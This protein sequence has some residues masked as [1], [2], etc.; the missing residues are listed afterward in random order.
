MGIGRAQGSGTLNNSARQRG[1]ELRGTAEV[2]SGSPPVLACRRRRCWPWSAGAPV[3]N[4]AKKCGKKRCSPSCAHF[5]ACNYTEQQNA[6][7]HLTPTRKRR[8]SCRH[9]TRRVNRWVHVAEWAG[10]HIQGAARGP[11][12]YLNGQRVRMQAAASFGR[13]GSCHRPHGLQL[14]CAE[15]QPLLRRFVLPQ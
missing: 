2:H 11:I 7:S 12:E 5:C 3:S 6:H 1:S 8:E 9:R 14:L 10:G 15:P 13:C 4:G